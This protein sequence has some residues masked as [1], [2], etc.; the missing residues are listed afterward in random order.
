MAKRVQRFK[1]QGLMTAL[2]NIALVAVF[3]FLCA[4]LLA[5]APVF[6]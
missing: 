5:T 4:K 1:H 2:F 3:A 6:M